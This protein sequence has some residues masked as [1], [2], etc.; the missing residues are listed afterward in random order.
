MR[1]SV[2]GL[3]LACSALK[4]SLSHRAGLE[5]IPNRLEVTSDSVGLLWRLLSTPFG[6]LPL[7][8]AKRKP[9]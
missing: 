6:F 4:G 3:L 7:G 5:L 9:N 8:V 1:R 2:F